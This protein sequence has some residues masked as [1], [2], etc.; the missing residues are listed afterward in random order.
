MQSGSI[1]KRSPKFLKR[2]YTS[3][4]RGWQILYRTEHQS[5]T[6]ENCSWIIKGESPL[7]ARMC[8]L[9]PVGSNKS[10][11]PA[12]EMLDCPFSHRTRNR[13][14]PFRNLNDHH[15]LKLVIWWWSEF[16][17]TLITLHDF[18]SVIDLPA[19]EAGSTFTSID[20]IGKEESQLTPPHKSLLW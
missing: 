13:L 9:Y 14:N 15:N 10:L 3:N 20:R 7:W 8:S 1:R 19:T 17:R 5:R 16:F 11:L 4:T 2:S 18:Y 6:T 12:A